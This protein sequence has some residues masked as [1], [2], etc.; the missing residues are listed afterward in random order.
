MLLTRPPDDPGKTTDLDCAALVRGL[1]QLH[2]QLESVPLHLERVESAGDKALARIRSIVTGA[3][4]QLVVMA[5]TSEDLVRHTVGDSLGVCESLAELVVRAVRRVLLMQIA[6]LRRA[7]DRLEARGLERGLSMRLD[8]FARPVEREL[9]SITVQCAA[10]QGMS[11]IHSAAYRAALTAAAQSLQALVARPDVVIFLQEGRRRTDWPRVAVACQRLWEVTQLRIDVDAAWLPHQL[12]ERVATLT[13]HLTRECASKAR[14]VGLAAAILSAEAAGAVVPIEAAGGSTLIVVPPD[15]PDQD[16]VATH[17]TERDPSALQLDAAQLAIGAPADD[18]SSAVEAPIER[19]RNHGRAIQLEAR[20]KL[21][22]SIDESDRLGGNVEIVYER[23]REPHGGILPI[24]VRIGR[25]ARDRDV[26]ANGGI[27]PRFRRYNA[28][29]ARLHALADRLAD[30]ASDE[31]S[32]L[33]APFRPP[34]DRAGAYR[35][36][37]QLDASITRRQALHMARNVVLFRVLVSEIDYLE[38][39]DRQMTPVIADAET[40]VRLS[41]LCGCAASMPAA[42]SVRCTTK[43]KPAPSGGGWMAGTMERIRRSK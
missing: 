15:L 35:L 26:L 36:L 4:H 16:P 18:Q 27:L 24:A 2:R 11:Q 38:G 10:C 43:R 30:L 3:R 41:E 5:T 7:S 19:L 31:R 17:A 32:P 37:Q 21:R 39:C 6:A 1:K 40:A 13:Q 8:D 42:K 33:K 23:L 29:L 28:M 25:D 34:A 22:T 14:R 9:R 20:L 12:A